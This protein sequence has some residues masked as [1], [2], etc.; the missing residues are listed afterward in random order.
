MKQTPDVCWYS[1]ITYLFCSSLW[2]LL[3]NLSGF[4]LIVLHSVTERSFYN[5]LHPLIV[6][7]LLLVTV[8]LCSSWIKKESYSL[9]IWNRD[10]ILGTQ[11]RREKLDVSWWKIEEI[12]QKGANKG[13]NERGRAMHKCQI[14]KLIIN[15]NKKPLAQKCKACF[16][17]LK[18]SSLA[19]VNE[20]KK[21]SWIF[22]S[23][24]ILSM[25]IPT[26]ARRIC[27]YSD[28]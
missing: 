2:L 19:T 7:R 8:S 28:K 18:L 10:E 1:L 26:I 6:T 3:S 23:L 15:D 11:N 20:K 5:L 13:K 16:Y 4:G 22:L 12:K 17:S 14:D 27:Q 25:S 21:K 9:I 24:V